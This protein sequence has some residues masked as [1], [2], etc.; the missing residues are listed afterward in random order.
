MQLEY[1]FFSTER[2]C[3]AFQWHTVFLCFT[4]PFETLRKYLYKFIVRQNHLQK[5]ASASFYGSSSGQGQK[6]W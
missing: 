4:K 5:S 3:F 6:V 2:S 1:F